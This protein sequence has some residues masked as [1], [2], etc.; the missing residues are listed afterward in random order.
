MRALSA[1][2]AYRTW[3]H[4]RKSIFKGKGNLL[5]PPAVERSH[6]AGQGDP[7]DALVVSP[8]G[9]FEIQVLFCA[10]DA[11]THLIPWTLRAR[12]RRIPK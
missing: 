2:G 7:P 6:L 12:L 9:D 11:G 5:P 3:R 4:G 8:D 1:P 10:G